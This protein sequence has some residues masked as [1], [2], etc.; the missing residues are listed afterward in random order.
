VTT[1]EPPFGPNQLIVRA[2][3][4]TLVIPY[5]DIVW[6]EAE[7]YYVRIHAR[8]RR[9]LV[10]LSLTSLADELDPARFVR[11]HRSAI[12]NLA[13]VR[14][15]VPLASGDQRIVLSDGTELRASRTYRSAL[16]ARLG[17]G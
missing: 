13:Y 1:G 17:R 9:T 4:R 3:G 2:D 15:L 12:V 8:G 6:I 10:R 16:D 5:D 7:D 14:E 11:V